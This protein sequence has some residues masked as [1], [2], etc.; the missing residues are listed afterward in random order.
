MSPG[1]AT[2]NPRPGAEFAERM[3]LRRARD[4][5]QP[6]PDLGPKRDDAG[7]PAIEVAKPDRAQQV[8]HIGAERAHRALGLG[9]GVDR[10]DEKDR[11]RGQ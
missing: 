5:E 7:Q 10:D 3:Q 8:G 6:I 2:A 9:P 4:A 1:V 11:G